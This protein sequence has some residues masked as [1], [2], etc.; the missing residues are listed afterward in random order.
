MQQ[1]AVHAPYDR[2]TLRRWSVDNALAR[3]GIPPRFREGFAT[4]ETDRSPQSAALRQ[5][6]LAW[7][8]RFDP[9]ATPRGFVMVGETGVGKT[10]LAAAI[11]R[12]VVERGYSVRWCNVAALFMKIRSTFGRDAEM[13]EQDLLD[14]L[15][16]PDLLVLDDLGVERPD[17]WVIERLYLVLGRRYEACRT[18]IV[19]SNYTGQELI[20][21]MRTADAGD[22][23]RRVVSRLAGM[24]ETIGEFPTTDF[25]KENAKRKTGQ[26]EKGPTR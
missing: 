23:A 22:L 5:R 16:A 21:R 11:A 8:E 18:V 19:T 25:R 14:E 6:A 13:D 4:F 15:V 20:D 2:E 7:A 12:R 17:G 9:L 24:A 10:H 26:R 3:S 1:T